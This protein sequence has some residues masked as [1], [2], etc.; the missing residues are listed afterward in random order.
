MD[1]FESIVVDYL[2]ADRS[3]FVNPQCLIQLESLGAVKKGA[4]WYCDTLT[5]DF[6]NST[7]FL[8]EVSYSTTLYSLQ[9][10]LTEWAQN[11]EQ[12]QLAVRRDCFFPNNW[13][14]RPWLFVRE[15]SITKA[16]TILARIYSTEGVK[17]RPKITTLEMTL[18]WL[19]K[20]WDRPVEAQKPIS[21]PDEM[22]N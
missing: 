5:A 9:K 14:I 4:S 13:P 16:V 6:R 18:P 17:L 3:L 21:I 7:V 20:T 10:R 22:V 15:Q 2:R 11:W 12:L 19:Y 1:H 8:C